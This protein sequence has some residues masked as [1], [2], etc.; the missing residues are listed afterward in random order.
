[1]KAAL[2]TSSGAAPA[3]AGVAPELGSGDPPA[4]AGGPPGGGRSDGGV[5]TGCNV[6][7]P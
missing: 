3:T 2:D 7:N 4:L 6:S 1:L 5:D